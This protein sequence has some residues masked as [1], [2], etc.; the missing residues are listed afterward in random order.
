MIQEETIPG[1]D[2]AEQYDGSKMMFE[3]EGDDRR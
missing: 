3:T 2:P 1:K